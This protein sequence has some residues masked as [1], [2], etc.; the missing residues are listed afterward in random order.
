M[1]RTVK[2]ME[3]LGFRKITY[4]ITEITPSY[5]RSTV[6]EMDSKPG[7]NIFKEKADFS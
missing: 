3:M 1:R 6:E 2:E 5:D 4:M 7:F